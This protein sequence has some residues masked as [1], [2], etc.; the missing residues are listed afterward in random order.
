[1]RLNYKTACGYIPLIAILLG[2]C[3]KVVYFEVDTQE[4]KQVVNAIIQPGEDAFAR[5]TLSADPL[6]LSFD[7]LAVTDAE[8]ALYINDVLDGLYTHDGAGNYSISSALHEVA[9]GDDLKMVVATPGRDTVTASTR[10]PMT[11]PILSALITDTIYEQV[12]YSYIDS[13]G[14]ISYIDT[15]VPYYTI[16]LTFNDPEG[17]NHY[18]LEVVYS[19]DFNIA[20][21][22]IGTSDPIFGLENEWASQNLEENGEITFCENTR[23]PDVT[24][25]G[26][27]KVIT[28]RIFAIETTFASNPKF[29]FKLSN[30]SEEYYQYL[31]TSEIQ[32]SSEYP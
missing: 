7:A 28:M 2:G 27:T 1:M 11:I 15:L 29:I 4:N 25:D 10:I 5:V 17:L 12:Y 14:N 24:F 30:L 20:T 3:E 32:V 21:A 23:F 31:R 9:A 19:D 26:K 22:C 16:T 13:L 6:A 8:I 18:A